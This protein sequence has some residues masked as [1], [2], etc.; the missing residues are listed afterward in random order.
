MNHV[1]QSTASAVVS[2]CNSPKQGDLA[3]QANL[4]TSTNP[5]RRWLHEQRRKWVKSTLRLLASPQAEALE[6]GTGCGVMTGELVEHFSHVTTLDINPTFVNHARASWPGIN[7]IEADIQHWCQPWA[8]NV[9]LCSEV[10]E[11]VRDPRAVLTNIRD[12]LVPG[13]YLVLT[14]PNRWSTAE[15]TARM[16]KVPGVTALARRVY[17]EPVDELGHI[18]LQTRGELMSHFKALGFEVTM[19]RDLSLYLPLIAELG[20]IT[21]QRILEAIARPI[22]GRPLLSQLLWTQ[23]F[24]LRRSA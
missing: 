20:G 16:L 9:A 7:A 24:L 11:H 21:G 17:G 23:C 4:Y 6:V 22:E 8:Y 12:S 18:S 5:T 13:G 14:T 3:F 19:H 1:T 2:T 15:L 10:L